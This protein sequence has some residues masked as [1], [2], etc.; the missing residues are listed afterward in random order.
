M[1]EA[2]TQMNRVGTV[3]GRI[4]QHLFSPMQI[5]VELENKNALIPEYPKLAVRQKKSPSGFL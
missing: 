4:Y 3:T 2:W 1:H 5:T